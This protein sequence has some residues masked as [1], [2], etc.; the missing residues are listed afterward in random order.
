MQDVSIRKK[1]LFSACKLDQKEIS[2]HLRQKTGNSK[3]ETSLDGRK[4]SSYK[5]IPVEG[6]HILGTLDDPVISITS[7]IL[8]ATQGHINSPVMSAMLRNSRI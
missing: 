5:S 4:K 3:K 6:F 2:A 8:T 1:V 7:Q